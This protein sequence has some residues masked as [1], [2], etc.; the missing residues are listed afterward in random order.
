MR[1]GR[2]RGVELAALAPRVNKRAAIVGSALGLVAVLAVFG[3][4]QHFHH[5]KTDVAAATQ[6]AA[7]PPGASALDAPMGAASG[8][9][10]AAVPLFGVT[11]LS[12][13]EA[14]PPPEPSASA[15]ASS[16]PAEQPSGDGADGKSGAGEGVGARASG[17]ARE[18]PQ[19]QARW[20]AR[21]PPVGASGAQGFTLTIPEPPRA[22]A[23]ER[24]RAQG[25]APR[26]RQDRQH[27]PGRRDHRAV[28]GDGVPPYL[29]KV[30]DDKLEIALGA[31]TKTVAKKKSSTKK[32]HW[33]GA[34]LGH[35]RS[36]DPRAGAGARADQAAAPVSPRRRRRLK[37]VTRAAPV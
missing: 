11:P 17:R 36:D 21:R 26:V 10:V 6:A 18:D 25:Q 7:L 15:V 37:L 16:A 24:S 31:E 29:A 23:V 28:Q 19:D 22:V 13:T 4:S 30:K 8:T 32:K 9:P 35:S 20:P 33:T 5:A 2:G 27:G 34:P 12:T 1:R 3:V 14:V